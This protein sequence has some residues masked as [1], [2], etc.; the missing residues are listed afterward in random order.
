MLYKNYIFVLI[1]AISFAVT[2]IHAQLIENENIRKEMGERA[3]ENIKRYSVDKTM[4]QW[5][6]LFEEVTSDT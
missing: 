5:K 3:S 4:N 1:I 6:L 2:P